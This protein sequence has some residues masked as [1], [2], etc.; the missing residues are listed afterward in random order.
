MDS[1]RGRFKSVLSLLFMEAA[2]A[3]AYET[4][5]GATYLSG[6]AGSVGVG[7]G[8]VSLM[9]SAAWI[10][11]VGQILGSWFAE[12]TP[13]IKRTTLRLAWI[14]RLLWVIPL[15]TAGVWGWQ[16]AHGI[17]VFP[18]DTWFLILV[19]TACISSW[20]A[21][22][23]A[24][25]WNS[26]M[27]ELIPLSIQGRFFGFRQRATMA[28]LVL[29]NAGAAAWISYAPG[30]Y[31]IG[32]GIIGTLAVG[33]GI[34]STW[35]LSGVPESHHRRLKAVTTSPGLRRPMN[36]ALLKKTYSGPLRDSRFTRFL[37]CAAAM[38][39]AIAIAGPYFPYYFTK[40]LGIPMERVSVWIILNC[41]GNFLASSFWGRKLDRLGDPRQI[42]AISGAMMAFSPLPYLF[43]SAE[44]I[45]A[46]APLEYFINGIAWSGFTLGMTAILYRVSPRGQ[47][48]LYF[49]LY[50]AAV[51]ISGASCALLGGGLAQLLVPW[52]GFRALWGLASVL[53]F[54]V[55]IFI[56]KSFLP[57]GAVL[58]RARANSV[59][60]AG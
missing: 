19:L 2:F 10:G 30:G 56:F 11:Q 36:W 37:V 55:V 4:W 50:S 29:A 60:T 57:A 49:S 59:K 41:T 42:L 48:R 1:K 43:P 33:S 46:I 6:L 35:L 14:A 16:Q 28:A 7:V 8:W 25:A 22:S 21:C 24:N 5:V 34:V 12:S 17:R 31:P 54:V 27:K 15:A 32:Y 47:N 20:I 13:S 23:S 44:V 52:G 9:T 40:E 26:W 18:R 45:R 51:G 3:M 38:N 39:G 53:R 58:G